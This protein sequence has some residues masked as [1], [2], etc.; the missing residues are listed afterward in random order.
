MREEPSERERER[1]V[2]EREK[3]IEETAAGIR[4]GHRKKG[5]L[6]SLLAI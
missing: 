1:K 2:R 3:R 5:D 6:L 4:A